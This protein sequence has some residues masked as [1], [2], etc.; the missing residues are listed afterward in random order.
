MLS[1]YIRTA[2]PQHF[3]KNI[4]V[5]APLIFAERFYDFN[6][7]INAIATFI[8]FSLSASAVYYL[9]D[10]FD[11][12]ED[13]KHPIKKYR[14][15]ASGDISVRVAILIYILLSVISLFSAFIWINIS[16]FSIVLIYLILNILYSWKLKHIVLLD[17]FIVSMGFVLR[18]LAGGYSINAHIS[19]WLILCVILLSLFLALAKRR[20]EFLNTNNSKKNITRKVLDDY[21]ETLLDQMIAITAGLSITSYSLY[22]ILNNNFDNLIFTVPIVIYGIF[23]YLYLI[24]VKGSG[25]NPEKELYKDNHILL[26]IMIWISITFVVISYGQ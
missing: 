8:I 1:Y 4:F 14:P 17:V 2:R 22:T 26:S 25:A 7:N 16:T 5:F 23:R 24:Y 15:I 11:R 6:S 12:T 9:N 10:I 21:N 13:V 19:E 20:Q 3:L 18:I